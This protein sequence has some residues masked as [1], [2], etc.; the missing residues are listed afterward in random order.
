MQTPELLLSCA[1]LL[2]AALMLL[3][4]VGLSWHRGASRPAWR[5]LHRATALGLLAALAALAAPAEP[6]LPGLYP[7]LLG[8]GVAVLVQVLGAVVGVFSDR[9]LDGEPRQARYA[10]ALAAVLGGV[11]L[12]LLA[13]HWLVLIAAWAG[14]GLALERLLCFYADRPFALLAAHKKRVADRAADAL[15]IAAALLSWHEVGSGS[16]TAL[17]TH[18]QAQGGLS[19]PLQLAAA[20]LVL[21]LIHI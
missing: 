20:L 17:A 3:A 2:P 18:V 4:A 15:L 12:L 1:A 7:T 5:A 10:A 6:L 16:L 14:V 13:D 19:T 9:Y 21:S 8:A 11:Q